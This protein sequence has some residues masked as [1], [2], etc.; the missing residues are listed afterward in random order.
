MITK[1]P[2]ECLDQ[3]AQAAAV[4]HP[5]DRDSFVHAAIARLRFESVIGPGTANCIIRQLL[6]TSAYRRAA[7]SVGRSKA[8]PHH[9]YDATSRRG[10]HGKP[11]KDTD[12]AA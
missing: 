8:G 12:D 7:A 4:L 10:R 9:G 3:V 5:A 6:M 11:V 1:L 2:D